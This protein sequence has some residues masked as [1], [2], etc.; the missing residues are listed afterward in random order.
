MAGNWLLNPDS[1]WHMSG[2]RREEYVQNLLS[3]L[4]FA[5][6]PSPSTGTMP[7]I[8]TI[9]WPPSRQCT[10]TPRHMPVYIFP[11]RCCDRT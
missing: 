11:T 10:E 9:T 1:L 3:T 4:V 7:P 2:W 6:M 8:A 5:D